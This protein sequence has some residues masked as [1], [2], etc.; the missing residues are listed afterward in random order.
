LNKHALQTY[1][2]RGPPGTLRYQGGRLL[3]V[4]APPTV[5]VRRLALEVIRRHNSL[6]PALQETHRV[7]LRWSEDLGDGLPNPEADTRETHY[8]P[9]SPDLQE[10]VTMIVD[11]SPFAVFVRKLYRTAATGRALAIELGISH[12]KLLSERR[13]ALWYHRG[14]FE[15]EHI[16][17]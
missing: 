3:E 7:L 11:G 4:K 1:V 14:R 5:Q 16:Y 2:D 8:D 13:A 10:K 17:G 6:E 12:T 15:A 9:L